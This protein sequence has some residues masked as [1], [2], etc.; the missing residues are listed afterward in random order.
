MM[1]HRF[2][3]SKL[4]KVNESIEKAKW[5]PRPGLVELWYALLDK[6]RRETPPKPVLL[7]LSIT[8]WN[9]YSYKISWQASLPSTGPLGL[10]PIIYYQIF[11]LQRFQEDT[12]LFDHHAQVNIQAVL[13]A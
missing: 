4:Q 9:N 7:P 6:I 11:T 2:Y 3:R 8:E 12:K 1:E 10:D 13:N 5:D